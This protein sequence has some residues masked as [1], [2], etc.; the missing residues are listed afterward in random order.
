MSGFFKGLCQ[1][2]PTA[3]GLKF[4]R[5]QAYAQQCQ[6]IA[7]TMLRIGKTWDDVDAALR[8]N[9]IKELMP[10]REYE[11]DECAEFYKRN[12]QLVD[13]SWF[14]A[15]EQMKRDHARMVEDPMR[16]LREQGLLPSNP[17]FDSRVESTINRPLPKAR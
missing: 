1:I 12:W 8:Y 2:K 10:R 3:S 9:A 16:F 6:Q 15:V 7:I 4:I 5:T 14:V 13:L 17:M 11:A